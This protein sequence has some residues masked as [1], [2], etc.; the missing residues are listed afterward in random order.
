MDGLEMKIDNSTLHDSEC[1]MKKREVHAIK[2]IEKRVNESKMQKQEGMDGSSSSGYDVDAERA[3][4]DK[5]VCNIENAVVGPSY[6]NDTLTEVHD[7]NNDKFENVFALGIQNHEQPESILYTYV[8]NENNSNII[9]NKPNMDPDRGKEEHNDVDN[10]QERALFVSLVN[11]I[12]CEVEL[13][14]L[15]TKLSKRMIY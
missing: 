12:K 4:V 8:V 2:K 11:K 7:S 14:R 6:D 3:R 5:V 9:S 13:L 15:I 10:E 1:H